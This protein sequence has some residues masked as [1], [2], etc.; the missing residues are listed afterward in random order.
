M[1]N[2]SNQQS[3]TQRDFSEALDKRQWQQVLSLLRV[4]ENSINPNLSVGVKTPLL[5]AIEIGQV[6]V[7]LALL[8]HSEINPNLSLWDK[9]PLFKAIETG[10]VE[11]VQALLA[12][13]KIDPNLRRDK[14]ADTPLIKAIKAGQVEIVRALLAH[15]KTDPNLKAKGVLGETM[16]SPLY[17]VIQKH[18]DGLTGLVRLEIVKLL[19]RN[20]RTR[21]GGYGL[22]ERVF[23]RAQLQADRHIQMQILYLLL[24]CGSRSLG[25]RIG[26]GF[27]AADKAGLYQC[28]RLIMRVSNSWLIDNIYWYDQSLTPGTVTDSHCQLLVALLESGVMLRTYH[29]TPV[30]C[31]YIK[32]STKHLASWLRRHYPKVHARL[33]LVKN[34][35]LWVEDFNAFNATVSSDH[36]LPITI[37][38]PDNLALLCQLRATCKMTNIFALH[39]VYARYCGGHYFDR[40]IAYR[41]KLYPSDKEQFV[42]DDRIVP[43]LTGFFGRVSGRQLV[44]QVLRCSTNSTWLDPKTPNQLTMLVRLTCRG[45]ELSQIRKMLSKK[46]IQIN[47]NS[48]NKSSM[49][50]MVKSIFFGFGQVGFACFGADSRRY[51]KLP[52]LSKVVNTSMIAWYAYGLVI[53]KQWSLL[54]ALIHSHYQECLP[55][56]LRGFAQTGMHLSPEAAQAFVRKFVKQDKNSDV[57]GATTSQAS[58]V[59]QLADELSCGLA[60]SGQYLPDWNDINRVLYGNSAE[61]RIPFSLSGYIRGLALLGDVTALQHIVRDQ[62]QDPSI[63]WRECPSYYCDWY[64]DSLVYQQAV[65]S[66]PINVLEIALAANPGLSGSSAFCR[67]QPQLSEVDLQS[68]QDAPNGVTEQE[69]PAAPQQPVVHS[70]EQRPQLKGWMLASCIALGVGVSAGIALGAVCLVAALLMI[71]VPVIP[72]SALAA[73]ASVSLLGSGACAVTQGCRSLAQTA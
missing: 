53:A 19:L 43:R 44:A 41:R 14:Y 52:A 27:T 56:I 29:F 17:L 46:L 70:P 62:I 64:S 11:M 25:Y 65:T 61:Y 28:A 36:E 16:I 30:W 37:F 67:L 45:W 33:R 51:F 47:R 69:A 20:G 21:L 22:L 39:W 5:K 73:V 63:D 12:H 35:S 54:N 50:S 10:Q 2:G 6:E 26:D 18:S 71:A 1:K 42:L 4:P 15:K 3:A 9:T 55:M 40:F 13:P 59:A 24:T 38:Q 57:L 49:I 31:H 8:K 23:D 60:L 68:V 7:V 48:Q 34:R 66:E 32:Y 72:V 58:R